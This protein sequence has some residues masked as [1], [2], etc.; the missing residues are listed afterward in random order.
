MASF[1]IGS[2]K[3][4]LTPPADLLEKGRIFLW[5]FGCRTGPADSIR[6]PI[7]T[8]ALAVSD[9]SGKC[10]VLVSLDLCALTLE[11][12]QAVRARVKQSRGLSPEC[13][14]INVTHTHSAPVTIAIPTWNSG[15]DKPDHDY[16]VFLADQVVASIEEAF[17]TRMPAKL[18][19]ARGRTSIGRNRH[20][21][22][23]AYDQTLDVLRAVND[24]GITIAVAFFHGCH[25]VCLI[26]QAISSDYPGVA[27]DEVERFSGGVALFFQGYGG[28]IDPAGVDMVETGQRLG[29]DVVALLQGPTKVLTGA[30]EACL[31]TIE[32]PLQPLDPVA[33]LRA[34]GSDNSNLRRWAEYIDSLGT[35]VPSVL[36]V[37]LQ[38]IRLGTAPDD[39]YLVAS[40]HE[41]VAEFSEPVRAKWAYPRVTLMGY[42]NSQM[43]YLPSRRVL[44]NPPCSFPFCGNY[45]GGTSFTWYGHRAPVIEG[46]DELFVNGNIA[47]RIQVENRSGT[48]TE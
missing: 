17:D 20:F 4:E 2:S 9:P 8:R 48:C 42:S 15:V 12:T 19:Y 32:I 31:S 14:A 43:S 16:M 39:W 26:S 30:V 11:F 37:Q 44:L 29:K 3:R 22:G 46:V 34:K 33:L 35:G 41:V 23:G 7:W 6:D 38:A 24:A 25:P 47:L 45:E 1:W 40:S 21:T 10:V 28:T 5:G 36:P 13:V 18:E 27:R